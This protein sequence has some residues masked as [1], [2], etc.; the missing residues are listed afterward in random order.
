[1]IQHIRLRHSSGKDVVVMVDCDSDRLRQ[2]V[3][4]R[5]EDLFGI[6]DEQG[7]GKAAACSVDDFMRMMGWLK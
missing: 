7:N 1:M 2:Y 5:I 4:E 3:V 6:E